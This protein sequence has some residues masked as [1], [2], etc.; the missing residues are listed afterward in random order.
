MTE[1]TQRGEDPRSYAGQ[2]RR[3]GEE[4]GARPGGPGDE[5][6]M[7]MAR[8]GAAPVPVMANT[9]GAAPTAKDS[10]ATGKAGARTKAK[11]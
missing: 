2:E 5:E 11:M 10:G 8:A 1:K 9:E 6:R 3:H 4:P 7:T